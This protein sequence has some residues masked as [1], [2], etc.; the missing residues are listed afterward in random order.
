M[1]IRKNKKDDINKTS[2]RFILEETYLA[3]TNK[4]LTLKITIPIK[5]IRAISEKEFGN[6]FRDETMHAPG[7]N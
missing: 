1:G 2:N 5:D 7:M 4:K 3:F 6:R